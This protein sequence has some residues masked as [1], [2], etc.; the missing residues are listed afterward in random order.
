MAAIGGAESFHDFH[1]CT[2][3]PKTRGPDGSVGK[4]GAGPRPCHL[5]RY[6]AALSRLT[7][8]R[9]HLKGYA[10]GADGPQSILKTIG[11]GA[12]FYDHKIDFGFWMFDFEAKATES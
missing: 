8:C 11:D 2:Q 1:H 4:G 6:A 5:A 10:L 12:A 7:Q 3:A 9:R